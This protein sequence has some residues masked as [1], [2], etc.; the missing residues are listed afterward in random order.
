MTPIPV[1]AS[2]QAATNL[3]APSGA[4]STSDAAAGGDAF[5]AILQQ[6]LTATADADPLAALLAARTDPM[7]DSA[8]DPLTAALQALSDSQRLALG[9]RQSDEDD[10]GAAMS[11]AVGVNLS[12]MQS[13][14]Q[15]PALP[16]APAIAL[17]SA[18]SPVP[19][20]STPAPLV[21]TTAA[22]TARSAAIIAADQGGVEQEVLAKGAAEPAANFAAVAA[23]VL[24]GTDP[25]A[26]AA[27]TATP[28][29]AIASPVGTAVWHGD[30]ANSVA[31]VAG[32]GQSRADLVLTP[33]DLGRVEVSIKVSGDQA[34]ASFVSAS[35]AV[36]EALEGALP[37][38]REVLAESG[39]TLTQA[40]I[41]AETSGQ[42]AKQQQNGDNRSWQQAAGQGSAAAA[43][44]GRTLQ[45]VAAWHTGGRGMVDV[46]A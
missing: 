7:A 26:A 17:P 15:P 20:D 46:F 35:P 4:G 40:H 11:D 21:D 42:S 32:Q 5:M 16:F 14:Q 22:S 44:A 28:S 3:A 23:S 6:Q 43:D 18:A 37:R 19:T 45:S 34:T 38:L 41:G 36:R 30:V 25:H 29:L 1:A 31:W 27:R 13:L 33:P 8:G 24:H 12:D 9:A 39:V 10:K 2:A